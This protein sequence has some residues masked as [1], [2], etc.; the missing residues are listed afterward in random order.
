MNH[1]G[2]KHRGAGLNVIITKKKSKKKPNMHDLNFD[3]FKLSRLSKLGRFSFYFWH[4]YDTNLQ[5]LSIQ[6]VKK[7]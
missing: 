1:R 7:S 6:R 4:R 3:Q 2:L 5:V